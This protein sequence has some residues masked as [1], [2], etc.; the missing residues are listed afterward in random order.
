MWPCERA[1]EVVKARFGVNVRSV[2]GSAVREVCVESSR[3]LPDVWSGDVC[4]ARETVEMH[5]CTR[6]A[7]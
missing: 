2:A 7:L 4:A 1:G 6:L 3:L 5:C